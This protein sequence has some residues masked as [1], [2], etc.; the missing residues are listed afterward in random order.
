MGNLTIFAG[1]Y[2]GSVP[3]DSVDIFDRRTSTRSTGP[4]LSVARYSLAAAAASG[5]AVFAGGA[6][7]SSSP[8]A[9]VDIYNAATGGW[10]KA[11][12]AVA[13]SQLA[14]ASVGDAVLFI[15]GLTVGVASAVVDIFNATL[16]ASP[17]SSTVSSTARSIPAAAAVGRLLVVAGGST[18]DVYDT[19]ARA[20]SSG[21]PL[22]VA[23]NGPGGVGLG[24]Q[25]IIAGGISSGDSST[26]I[27]VLTLPTPTPVAPSPPATLVRST[28]A[29]QYARTS[30]VVAAP[31][32]SRV[33]IAGG[34]FSS[35]G[36]DVE[37]FDPASNGVL[38]L[39]LPSGGR[40]GLAAATSPNGS[41]AIFGGRLQQQ[42]GVLSIPRHLQQRH[43]HPSPLPDNSSARRVVTWRRRQWAT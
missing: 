20:W 33:V 9:A 27:D 43:Q 5:Y 31:A 23:R 35:P 36:Y 6:V 15:G 37:V 25:A 12:L 16:L 11:N 34:T 8:S 38:Y 29:L 22:A 32:G 40:G 14:A 42:P 7:T 1:G 3:V 39:A 17:W 21:T 30:S 41:M 19:A 26:A 18:V 28:A 24:Y 13:R 4:A 10:S 2:S